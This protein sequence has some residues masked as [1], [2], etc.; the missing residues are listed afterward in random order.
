MPTLFSIVESPAYPDLGPLYRRLGID[1]IRL[2][3]Q[4]KALKA[5]KTTPPDWVVAEFI[6]GFGNNYAGANISNLDVLLASLQKFSP[7]AKVI[8]LVSKDQHRYVERLAER[9]RLHAVLVLPVAEADMAAVLQPSAKA[10]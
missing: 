8:V 4:R 9:F 3:G 7:A 6:Y 5:L 1:E 2:P 10:E